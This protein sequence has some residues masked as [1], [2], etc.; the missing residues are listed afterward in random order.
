MKMSSRER[1]LLC[2]VVSVALG[3]L[4]YNFVFTKNSERLEEK[5]VERNQVEQ[6][7]EDAKKEIAQIDA[8]RTS[9]SELKAKGEELA[10]DYYPEIIQENLIKEIKTLMDKNGLKGDYS[11]AERNADQLVDLTP[12]ILDLP[13]SSVQALADI[14]KS[15]I[16]EQSSKKNTTQSNEVVSNNTETKATTTAETSTATAETATA[17]TNT[18]NTVNA[19]GEQ[20]GPTPVKIVLTI[21]LRGNYDS[22]RNFV[23]DIKDYGR[24]VASSALSTD[25]LSANDFQGQIDVEFYAIPKINDKDNEYLDWK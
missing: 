3:V 9:L 12:A 22:L 18:Q 7:Y 19:N 21:K 4:Y 23:Q 14:I 1:N 2:I 17:S 20:N 8:R 5:K 6:K 16:G 15:E 11:W 25:W 13:K 24:V 10:K